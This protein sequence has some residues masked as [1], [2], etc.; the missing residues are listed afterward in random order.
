MANIVSFSRFKCIYRLFD[1][2]CD[3]VFLVSCCDAVHETVVGYANQRHISFYATDR[4][5][6]STL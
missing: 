3:Y 4:N 1:R 6:S 2:Y 5:M